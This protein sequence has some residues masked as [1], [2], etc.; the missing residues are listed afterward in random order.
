MEY[1]KKLKDMLCDELEM[2]ASKGEMTAGTLE[3]VDK[4]THAIKSISTIIAMEDYSEDDGYYDRG[5]SYAR[6]RRRDEMGRY[7]KRRGEY[8]GHGDFKEELHAM[9]EDA[10]DQERIAIRKVLK[11]M[12]D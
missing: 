1:M 12:N 9:L 10:N 3:T 5:T 6:N 8:S 2:I 4:L 11:M 7:S